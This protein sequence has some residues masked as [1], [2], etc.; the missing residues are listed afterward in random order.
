MANGVTGGTAADRGK[1]AP[2]WRTWMRGLGQRL[3]QAREA[4]R[5]SQSELAADAGVSQGAISRLET[6]RGLATPLLVVL[7]TAVALRD[8]ARRL[9]PEAL[10]DE[11][12]VLV[13]S[14]ARHVGRDGCYEDSEISLDPA[15]LELV[16]TYR[17]LPEDARSE[18]LQI[19][20]RTA[21]VAR[22]SN[23]PA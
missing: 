20:R 17:A 3:R 7:K 19:A 22:R 15:A 23:G 1:T 21:S 4:A 18:L 6:G 11:T 10:P 13:E 2:D 8:A 16:T 12:A 14:L 5:L 9:G